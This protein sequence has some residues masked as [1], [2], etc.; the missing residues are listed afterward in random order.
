V[1]QKFSF[2][3]FKEQLH[4]RMQFDTLYATAPMP[5]Q[6]FYLKQSGKFVF[7]AIPSSTM[8]S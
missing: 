2:S 1:R 8:Q 5:L 7:P 3:P 4:H 6:K